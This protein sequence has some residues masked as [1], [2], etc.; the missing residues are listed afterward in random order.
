MAKIEKISSSDTLN[1]G[2]EK[3][4]TA[5]DALVNSS[6][7]TVNVGFTES[8]DTLTA[9]KSKYPSGRDGMFFVFDN[10]NGDGGHSYM[11]SSGAWK[12]LGI[13]Q[14]IEL[15]PN[16]VT[17]TKLADKSIDANKISFTT[18]GKNK[19]DLDTTVLGYL[20][21]SGTISQ[22]TGNPYETSGF[23]PIEGTS[24][25]SNETRF[26]C[27]YDSNYNFI[28]ERQTDKSG[29][30][31][32]VP[33]GASY[34]RSSSLIANRDKVQIEFSLAATSYEPYAL[35]V[36]HLEPASTEEIKDGAVTTNKV[37]FIDKIVNLFDKEAVTTGYYL[38][39]TT[40]NLVA[41]VD[42]EVSDFID[43]ST[44]FQSGITQIIINIGH[45]ACL[46]N[47]NQQRYEGYTHSPN[48][49]SIVIPLTDRAR[50]L[51]IGHQIK[52]KDL[53]MVTTENTDRYLPN[54]PLMLSMA[55][56]SN[57]I[58]DDNIEFKM[59]LPKIIYSTVNNGL[60]I[61]S[62]NIVCEDVD[63]YR[64][65]YEIASGGQDKNDS[66]VY[67][68]MS[69]TA[70]S[71]EVSLFSKRYLK[72]VKGITVKNSNSRVS[73]IKVLYIGDS[74][75]DE[76]Y[77]L[78]RI[79]E[80]LGDNVQL[81][82]RKTTR[83]VNHEGNGGWQFTSYM[84]SN[85][86]FLNPETGLFDFAYYLNSNSLATP[87][88]VVFN[89]GINDVVNLTTDDS[90]TSKFEIAKTTFDTIIA[91]IKSFSSS[92]K[93]AWSTPAPPNSSKAIFGEKYGTTR[94]Q[95]RVKYNNHL[96]TKLMIDYYQDKID[97]IAQHI[98]VDTDNNYKDPIH[99][100][101]TGYKQLGDYQTAYLNSLS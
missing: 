17:Y 12:D 51:R 52:H 9:L 95:W 33:A 75:I 99:C 65:R 63:N 59:T 19:F 98:V 23:I 53:V 14:G 8:F 22:V 54:T 49:S 86:P 71:L 43:I 11:W 21:E 79:K 92:I 28:G 77:I 55:I 30:A 83:S 46:Y 80:N 87:D 42:Y 72:S 5:I 73:P 64:F 36:K 24:V 70:P 4:N 31:I 91:N 32:T 26:C 100:N 78:E 15:A 93:I 2:R 16:T 3:I 45:T 27:F 81:I 47:V 37:N 7:N 85:S 13:Y 62:K 20:N 82:G 94:S 48:T 67:N 41:N 34:Y 56:D 40:G 88:L 60:E 29:I 44:L 101:E 18:I 66:F 90:V 1:T 58:I 61:I 10:G 68:Y 96:F 57:N 6:G 50:Y 39:P 35:K 84:G 76:G 25:V 69:E 74:Y 97:I 89:L 38:S